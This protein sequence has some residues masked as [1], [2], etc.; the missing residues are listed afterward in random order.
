MEVEYFK[1]KRK[2]SNAFHCDTEDDDP[3]ML[4]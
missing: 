1:I 3:I 4:L 2:R